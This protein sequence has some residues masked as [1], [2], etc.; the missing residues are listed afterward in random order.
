MSI[1]P[2]MLLLTG[3]AGQTSSLIYL[4]RNTTIKHGNYGFIPVQQDYYLPF[5]KSLILAIC[6]EAQEL[7][8]LSKAGDVMPNLT[9]NTDLAH[10]AAQV[11]I[12]SR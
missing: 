2:T 9:V 4:Y 1:C 3:T 11:R 10:K 8:K 5:L 6:F 12:L 7:S